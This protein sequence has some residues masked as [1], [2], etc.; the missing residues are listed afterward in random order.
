RTAG[1]EMSV[2]RNVYSA[3]DRA[4][5]TKRGVGGNID[6]AAQRAVHGQR[7]AV[8]RRVAGETGTVAGQMRGS[9]VML[10]FAGAGNLAFQCGVKA[11]IGVRVAEDKHAVA[12]TER[13]LHPL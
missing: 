8:N 6:I 9:G 4:M 5:A 13:D 2:C 3:T 12:G 7:A 1:R 10:D 11:V